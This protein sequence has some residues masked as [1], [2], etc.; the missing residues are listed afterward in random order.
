MRY[1]QIIGVA[2][3]LLA[4]GPALAQTET[5]APAASA[6]RVC[7][8]GRVVACPCVGGGEGAQTCSADGTSFGACECLAPAAPVAMAAGPSISE[9]RRLSLLAERETLAPRA[10]GYRLMLAYTI[11]M[12]IV[13]LGGALLFVSSDK[14]LP[15]SAT[16]LGDGCVGSG[17]SWSLGMTFGITWFSAGVV[18]SVL[19]VVF[20][21]RA[22]R[23]RRR[24]AEIDAELAGVRARVTPTGFELRF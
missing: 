2:G 5:E 24:V 9:E 14:N 7:E 18:L 23:A 10:R 17:C 6:G 22:H 12:P 20:L 19:A 8:P 21:P 11:V 15:N 16:F 4:A 1:V 3:V 13:A